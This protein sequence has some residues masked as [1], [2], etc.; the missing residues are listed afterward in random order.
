M[1]RSVVKSGWRKLSRHVQKLLP[2]LLRGDCRVERPRREGGRERGM[3]YDRAKNSLFGAT[4]E[5][6]ERAERERERAWQ[7]DNAD[8][9]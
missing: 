6:G 9:G 5:P 1:L 3:N 7:L 4:V 2:S 8:H